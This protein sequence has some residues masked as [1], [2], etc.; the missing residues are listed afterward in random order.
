MQAPRG[1]P[2]ASLSPPDPDESVPFQ[3]LQQTLQPGDVC[4]ENSG[5]ISLPSAS[6][7]EPGFSF[8]EGLDDPAP[9]DPVRYAVEIRARASGDRVRPASC[10]VREAQIRAERAPAARREPRGT[11]RGADI[12]QR[13]VP[14]VHAAPGEYPFRR[15][16]DLALRF[17]CPPLKACAR[18]RAREAAVCSH[19]P[20][21]PAAR[22]PTKVSR[23]PCTSR[24][25][26]APGAM[27]RR[28]GILISRSTSTEA[29]ACSRT[30][31]LLYPIPRHASTTSR[32][33]ARAS[34]RIDGKRRRNRG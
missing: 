23:A 32:C 8:P 25:P 18:T 16:P 14:V 22:A 4:G 3:S 9:V 2:A 12:H 6:A 29:R 28:T 26:E 30:A 1:S 24:S 11:Y 19:R 5:W 34:E 27:P 7:P 31:L 13:L 10:S 21:G 15:A 20:P 17:S 33:R